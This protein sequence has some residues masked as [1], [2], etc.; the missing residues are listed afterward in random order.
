MH[1]NTT[2]SQRQGTFLPTASSMLFLGILL[3]AMLCSAPALASEQIGA[4][5]TV[6]GECLI[7]RGEERFKAELN[8]PIMLKDEVS[9]KM[10]AQISIL[11]VDETRLTLDESSHASIDNYVYS[12]KNSDL[13][14]K[15]TKGTFRTIT[16]GI[17]K[18]NPE[19]F[20]ME[21]PL[22][23]LG[24]RGSDIYAIVQPTGE[25]AGALHLG[26]NHT[27]EIETPIQAASIRES[28]LRVRIFTNGIISPPSA[29]PPAMYERM[30]GLG[31]SPQPAPATEGSVTPTAPRVQT[32]VPA[33]IPK[34]EKPRPH[35]PYP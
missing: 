35:L 28:G 1:Q 33:I 16:G 7:V 19:G 20:N 32:T 5:D 25:E 29:I 18:R 21:T 11:F 24:I 34:P 30:E 22:A 14:F 17:V 31:P 4:V 15:F 13:L 12:D 3:F 26:D 10:G 9:T 23:S 2:T 27:L 8:Q 6:T